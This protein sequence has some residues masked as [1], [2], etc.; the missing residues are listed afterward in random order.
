MNPALAAR[1]FLLADYPNAMTHFVTPLDAITTATPL[2]T[3]KEQLSGGGIKFDTLPSLVDVVIGKVPGCMGEGS[4]VALLMGGLYLI[5]RGV[6]KWH[7]PVAYLT[8]LFGVGVLGGLSIYESFYSLFLG[9]AMLGAFFYG[10]RL[11]ND[12]YDNKRSGA[13][14]SGSRCYYKCYS[15][16]WRLSRRCQLQYTAYEYYGATH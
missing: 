3:M 10:N 4:A 9:G 6:I 8:T 1:A 7:I 12:S 11:Y 16:L 14:C 2:A 5:A 15:V 13:F